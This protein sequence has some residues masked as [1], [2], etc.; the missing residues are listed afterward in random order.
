MSPME[1]WN[2]DAAAAHARTQEEAEA[3]LSTLSRL[4]VDW[5]QALASLPRFGPVATPFDP[6]RPAS[7]KEHG[8]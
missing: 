7:P 1:S 8:A 6:L 5:N 3:W 4:Q 2:L